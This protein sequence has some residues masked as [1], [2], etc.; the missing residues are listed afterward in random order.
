MK[1]LVDCMPK[2]QRL[3]EPGDGFEDFVDGREDV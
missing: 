2:P 1:I 3:E